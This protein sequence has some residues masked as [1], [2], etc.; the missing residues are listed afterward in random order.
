M[1]EDSS[2]GRFVAVVRAVVRFT[3]VMACGG[4]LLAAAEAAV[5][6]ASA[7]ALADLERVTMGSRG[8][9]VCLVVLFPVG[10]EDE[11]VSGFV[12]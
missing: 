3:F 12:A 10:L 4:F 7:L 5:A 2:V 1:R 11:L 9:I 8:L 6:A